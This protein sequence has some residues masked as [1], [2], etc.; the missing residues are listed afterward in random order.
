[1]STYMPKV[2]VIVPNYNHAKFLKKRLDSILNQTYQDIEVIILDDCSPDDSQS[3]IANYADHPKVKEIIYNTENSGSTF[4]QWN[5]GIELATGELIWIAESDDMAEPELLETL[6]KPF[7]ANHKLVLAYSQSTRMND[8]DEISGTWL[9]W[10]DNLDKQKRFKADFV[11]SGE[12]YI[13]CYLIYKNTIPNASAVLFK[14]QAYQQ[15]GGAQPILKTT[16]DWEV[17]LRLL[18]VGE[19][20]YCAKPL[21]NFRYHNNSVIAKFSTNS[22]ISDARKQIITMY[23]FYSDFLKQQQI[24]ELLVVSQ[25]QKK[26]H[27]KKQITYKIRKHQFKGL[28]QDISM[29]LT[30]N[31]LFNLIYLIKTFLQIVYFS[32][33]KLLFDKLSGKKAV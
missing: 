3:I 23:G 13:K 29:S 26:T 5:K 21:N 6:I 10:T 20:F 24:N 25:D 22:K 19:I 18:S 17:W 8:A 30:D 31:Y 2:S 4:F 33:F 12:E 14:K 27:L 16:G 28:G 1:M 32:T 9:D 7:E 11:M 15:I